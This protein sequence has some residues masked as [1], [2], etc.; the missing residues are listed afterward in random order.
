MAGLGKPVQNGES[1]WQEHA[2]CMFFKES[3]RQKGSSRLLE[4]VWLWSS[5]G[6]GN[7]QSDCPVIICHALVIYQPILDPHH[8]P[9]PKL[10]VQDRLQKAVRF[11]WACKICNIHIHHMTCDPMSHPFNNNKACS[12]QHLALFEN[13]GW[14]QKPV[15]YKPFE[16]EF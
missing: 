5:G 6:L 16:A 8:M 1:K 10:H 7:G 2:H 4:L 15:I 14:M 3:L 11:F 13:Q 9:L 12:P